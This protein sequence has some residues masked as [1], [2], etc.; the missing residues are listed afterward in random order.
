MKTTHTKCLCTTCGDYFNSTAAF[1]KH[2]TGE[3]ATGRR[4]M[5]HQER[6]SIKMDTN[7]QGYWVTALRELSEGDLERMR[8]SDKTQESEL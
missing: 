5:T 8:G 3:H 6:R 7:L 4:C 1:D 2:R